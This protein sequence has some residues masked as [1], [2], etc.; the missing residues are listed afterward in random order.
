MLH[1]GIYP[2]FPMENLASSV[3]RTAENKK[4]PEQNPGVAS[5]K[6]PM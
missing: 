2:V 1:A 6:T 4:T 5:E 3:S